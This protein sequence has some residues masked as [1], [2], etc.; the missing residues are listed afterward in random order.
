MGC[1]DNNLSIGRRFRGFAYK[2]C[3]FSWVI[4]KIAH[5]CVGDFQDDKKDVFM[6]Q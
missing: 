5:V 2:L 6:I 1:Y 4:L 3:D